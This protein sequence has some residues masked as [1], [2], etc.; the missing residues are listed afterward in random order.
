[1]EEKIRNFRDLNIWKLGVEIVEDIYKLT[2]QC[3]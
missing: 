2:E 3:A 1:M